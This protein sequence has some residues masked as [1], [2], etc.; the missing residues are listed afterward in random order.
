M[1]S[2]V[3]YFTQ[4]SDRGH[5]F[6]LNDFK[7]LVNRLIQ[8]IEQHEKVILIGVSFAL[9]DF[10]E[11]Y[12]LRLSDK[13]HVMETGGMKG[14]K[15]E[16]TRVALHD[17]LRNAFGGSQIHSE[18]G[19]TELMHQ[20]YAPSSG[21]FQNSKMTKVLVRSINDPFETHESSANGLLN[22]FDPGNIDS[23]SFIATDDIATI[24]ENGTFEILG[25]SD[26]SEMRG[27]NLLY[28]SRDN[29]SID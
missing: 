3:K 8:A 17:A 29:F 15:E 12:P 23:C 6:F 16:V 22:I 27:C 26:N 5:G 11:K 24:H 4:L 1:V 20:F 13:I 19:M 21:V 18:Y 2:M 10:A 7:S 14:R 25:R 9:L 28:T